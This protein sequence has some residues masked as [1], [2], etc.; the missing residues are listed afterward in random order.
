MVCL[1]ALGTLHRPPSGFGSGSEE[2]LTLPWCALV[3]EVRWVRN[4]KS[5]LGDFF[6]EALAACQIPR[7][8]DIHG[9]TLSAFQ[10]E[11]MR[12]FPKLLFILL[13]VYSGSSCEWSY[14][15]PCPRNA[16]LPFSS[17]LHAAGLALPWGPCL[18]SWSVLADVFRVWGGAE[19][20][21]CDMGERCLRALLCCR[22]PGM[23]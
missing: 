1:G 3:C 22:Q 9:T 19:R 20:S 2:H 5:F 12:A 10:A 16:R 18:R 4:P 23:A 8:F 21:Q 7:L 6:E 15:G 17:P 13:L 14:L 11:E